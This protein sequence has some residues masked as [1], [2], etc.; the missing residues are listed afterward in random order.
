MEG[1]EVSARTVAEAVSLAL[2]R[3]GVDRSEVEIEVLSPGKA[4]ILGFGAEEARIRVR[5]RP[6]PSPAEVTRFAQEVLERLLQAMGV[7]G[8]VELREAPPEGAPSFDISG[9]ELG[10][11]IGRRGETLSALQYMVNR[12]VGQR[13]KLR[14]GVVVD[15]EGYRRRREEALKGLARRLA[16]QVK[17][18]GQSVTL[19]PMPAHERRIVHLALRDYSQVVS[20]SVGEGER[21]KVAISPKR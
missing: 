11:L 10:I 5:P 18:T 20:Q 1:L 3:L 12:I 19:E 21:R 6:Q 16:E 7:W 17:A 13:Y 4:G 9:K 8:K 15:V 14:A 2:E